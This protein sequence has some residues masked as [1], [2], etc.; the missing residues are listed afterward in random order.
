M[1]LLSA[2]DIHYEW[3]DD[4][5]LCHECLEHTVHNGHISVMKV[6]LDCP[7]CSYR[8]TLYDAG[9]QQQ[10]DYTPIEACLISDSDVPTLELGTI[11]RHGTRSPPIYSFCA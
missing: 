6:H 9:E 4:A 2:I 1:V 5:E 10:I 8:N 11:I 3:T 7:L